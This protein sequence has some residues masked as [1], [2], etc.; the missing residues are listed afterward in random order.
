MYFQ[1]FDRILIL[2]IIMLILVRVSL[3]LVARGASLTKII[4]LFIL[5]EIIV[6]CVR[7]TKLWYHVIMLIMILEFFRLK[8][9]VVCS[10]FRPPAWGSII[11]FALTVI[12]VC[13]ARIGMSL[14]VSITRR[15]GDEA[16]VI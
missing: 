10:L 4:I 3:I 6:F 13:E 14:I 8:R 12:I 16:V 11:L 1:C 7:I 5:A 2:I 9:F 15:R